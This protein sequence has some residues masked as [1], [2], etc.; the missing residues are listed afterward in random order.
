MHRCIRFSLLLAL[1]T[2][3]SLAARTTGPGGDDVLRPTTPGFRMGALVGGSLL[4]SG[5]EFRSVCNCAYNG[6][7]GFGGFVGVWIEHP[8]STT[9]TAG[10]DLA[11]SYGSVRHLNTITAPEYTQNGDYALVTQEQQADMSFMTASARALGRMQTGLGALS[12]HAGLGLDLLISPQYSDVQRMVTPGYVYYSTR[13]SEKTLADGAMGDYHTVNQVQLQAAV[14]VGYDLPVS[15]GFSARPELTFLYPLT[16][17][18]TE[19]PDWKLSRLQLT[20]K[21][22]F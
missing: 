20:V 10:I 16:S 3:Y 14:G 21:L 6:G 9:I 2:T 13:S 1:F 19:Y 7:T 4:L 15:T 12:V 5:G 8:V 11:F 17:V 22:L 18:V